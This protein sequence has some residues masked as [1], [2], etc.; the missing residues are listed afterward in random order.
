MVN[1]TGDPYS[2]IK[3]RDSEGAKRALIAASQS[4]GL[5][6]SDNDNT[7][8]QVRPRAYNNSVISKSSLLLNSSPNEGLLEEA[9]GVKVNKQVKNYQDHQSQE[10]QKSYN[11]DQ[12]FEKRCQHYEKKSLHE[13]YNQNDQQPDVMNLEIR[14]WPSQEQPLVDTITSA[15]LQQEKDLPSTLA[16]SRGPGSP[17]IPFRTVLVNNIPETWSAQDLYQVY[18][19][20]SYYYT[21]TTTLGATTLASDDDQFVLERKV[22]G[23]ALAEQ[24]QQSMIVVGVFLYADSRR[25]GLVEFATHAMACLACVGTRVTAEAGG[26]QQQS[27]ITGQVVPTDIWSLDAWLGGVQMRSGPVIQAYE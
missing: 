4:N 24:Q 16:P 21:T 6:T 14:S 22:S 25:L 17:A 9:V 1:Q 11:H 5:R 20:A 23:L 8:L 15:P 26:Q 19:G 12:I 13:D 2:F 18:H 27:I 3:F 10:K 7:K